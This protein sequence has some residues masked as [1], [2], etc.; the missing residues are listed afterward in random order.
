[1]MTNGVE[2]E[3]AVIG[4]ILLDGRC[5]PVVEELL[6]AEDFALE[7]DQQIYRAAVK[8]AREDKPVDL[9]T[10]LE[11]VRSQHADVSSEYL[12]QLLEITPT[13]A[14][15]EVYARQVRE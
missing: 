3:Q 2:A 7:S 10:I 8:L 15:V 14:N 4:S 5:L 13:A 9:V 6:R 11:E 12:M 1:M